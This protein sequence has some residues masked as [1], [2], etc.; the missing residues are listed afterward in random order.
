MKQKEIVIFE[1]QDGGISLKVPFESETV[2]LNLNQIG[3]LFDR[4]KSV[5]S[6]HIKKIFS[7]EELEKNQA[8]AFFATVQKE[9]KKD[10]ER[11]IEYFNLDVVLSVGYRVNSLKGMEFRKWANGI[12]KNYILKGFAFNKAIL[13]QRGFEELSESIELVKKALASQNYIHDI[14]VETL[15]LIQRYAK[16]WSLLLSYDENKLKP[17]KEETPIRDINVFEVE[18]IIY[19]LKQDLLEKG[20]ASQLFGQLRVGQTVSSQFDLIHQT[21]DGAVLYPSFESRAAHLFYFFI[22]NHIFIDGNKRIGSLMFLIYL[23]HYDFDLTKISNESLVS[24]ALLI[25]QSDVNDKEIMIQ[26]ITHLLKN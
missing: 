13:A 20:E 10:V 1:S 23:K 8:V 21:F 11:T 24:Q 18:N 17:L 14:G 3:D 16:S 15:S 25:A 9:G 12:L 4:D 22:K 26:L 5:I 6:R 19:S 7:N 2:W